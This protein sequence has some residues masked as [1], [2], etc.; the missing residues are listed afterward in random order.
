[1][2][3]LFWRAVWDSMRASARERYERGQMPEWF[4]PSLLDQ[5]EAPV[6]QMLREGGY[7]NYQCDDTWLGGNGGSSGGAGGSGGG[8]GGGWWREEDPYWSMRDWGDH[9][10]RW[11]TLGFAAVVAGVNAMQND[12]AHAEAPH[13]RFINKSRM[14]DSL[15]H[16]YK[17]GH[18]CIQHLLSTTGYTDLKPMW[19]RD[20]R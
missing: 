11:W 19:T 15:G 2:A 14:Q 20:N 5:E 12:E 9:P 6:N 18:P 10:M 17:T 3:S 4:D 8:G 16:T 13:N 7:D 1:M